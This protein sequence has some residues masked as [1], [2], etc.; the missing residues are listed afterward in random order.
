MTDSDLVRLLGPPPDGR[1]ALDEL[2]R[3]ADADL[4]A[5]DPRDAY[6]PEYD[7][8]RADTV[9]LRDGSPGGVAGEVWVRLGL[10]DPEDWEAF[11]PRTDATA[12]LEAIDDALD[13]VAAR[14]DAL[15]GRLGLPGGFRFDLATSA[16]RR[17]E[18]ARK[19]RV[20]LAGTAGGG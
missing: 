17:A 7:E 9:V 5:A 13:E 4:R 15:A 1:P 3:G 6:D 11:D 20:W 18:A 12:Y 2:V 14:L 8:L 16:Q 10:D 19:A